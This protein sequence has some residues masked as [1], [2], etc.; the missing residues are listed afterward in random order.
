ML[1]LSRSSLGP[2]GLVFA[3]SAAAIL[4]VSTPDEASAKGFRFSFS[5]NK[6]HDSSHTDSGAPKH[7][8]HGDE[9][10][11]PAAGS[12]GPA[13]SV[14]PKGSYSSDDD[15]KNETGSAQMKDEPASETA[16]DKSS[17]AVEPAATTA[18]EKSTPAPAASRT[19]AS[20]NK[21]KPVKQHPLAAAHP[22]MDVVVCEGGCTNAKE[23]PEAVYV[24]PTTASTVTTVSEV[25]PTSSQVSAQDPMK[26]MIICLGG[27]YDTPKIYRSPMAVADVVATGWTA[28]VVPLNAQPAGTGSGA[29]MRRIDANQ[30]ATSKAA[31]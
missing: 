5:K 19:I 17:P 10:A 7:R 18:E 27:C 6:S 14:R 28:T 26:D 15:E 1:R 23:A 2:F 31:Q 20:K 4:L 12:D 3:V 16:D 8:E 25:K 22:G 21:P 13:F 29:W 9:D 11:A 24:Q 30:D